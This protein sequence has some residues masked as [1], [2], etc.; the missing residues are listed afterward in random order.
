MFIQIRHDMGLGGVSQIT[1]KNTMTTLCQLL[2]VSDLNEQII[3]L[4]AHPTALA[5]YLDHLDAL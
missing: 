5:V 1:I 4:S 2:N 3:S